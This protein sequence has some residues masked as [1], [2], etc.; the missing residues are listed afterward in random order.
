MVDT[1]LTDEQQLLALHQRAIDGHLQNDVE[2]LLRDEEEDYVIGSRG[3]VFHPTKEERRQQL[4]PYI[5]ATRFEVYKDEI[6][7]IVK[8][9]VDGT[10]GWVICQML[11]RGE[12]DA[13][14]GETAE[15]AF[16]SAWIELSEKRNGRWIR[17]G[18]VSN[19]RPLD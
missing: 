6:P 14:D 4:G 13:G 10:L 7:P 1:K 19:I 2:I 16:N 5:K 8:V 12:P 17:M 3:G 11:V 18:Q 9:S 15:G